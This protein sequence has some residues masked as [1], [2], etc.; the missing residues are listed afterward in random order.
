VPFTLAAPDDQQGSAD[1]ISKATLEFKYEAEALVAAGIED[2]SSLTWY[3]YDEAEEA[4]VE[5]TRSISP[6]Q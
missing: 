1:Q 3:V 2:A 6:T 5:C 4:W